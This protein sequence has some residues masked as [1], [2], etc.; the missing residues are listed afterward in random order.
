MTIDIYTTPQ[1][2][3][4]KQLKALLKQEGVSYTEHDV[5][6]SDA[7]LVEMQTLSGGALS[8]PVVVVAKGTELQAVAIG[9]DEGKKLLGLPA[10]EKQHNAKAGNIAR[11]TCPQCGYVQEAPIPTTSCVPFY[12]CDGCKGTMQAVGED[13]C[14]FCSYADRPC[15]L[16]SS[17]EGCKGG[18]CSL[19][20]FHHP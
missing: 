10:G 4:C 11:L 14:V 7:L 2:G 16:K 19:Q 5:T 6:R 9:F 3:F 15:P 13:C 1:C 20:S 17:E 8:V 18:I 12:V